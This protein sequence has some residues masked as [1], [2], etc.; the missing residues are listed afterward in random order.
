[1]RCTLGELA[2]RVGGTILGN[3]DVEIH[4]AS[5]LG[6]AAAGEITLIDES[7][8]SQ[9]L[10][11]QTPAVAAVVSAKS[12]ALDAL[13]PHLHRL[14]VD[15]PHAAFAALVALFRPVRP[16]SVEGISPQASIHPTAQLAADV[17]VYP[18]ATI[19]AEATIGAGSVIYPGVYVG[20]CCR[21]GAGVTIFPNAVLYENT[22][23]GD[24][25]VL[26]A[27]VVLGAYG[28]GYRLVDGRHVLSSQL[29]YVEI[30]DD[31]EIGSGS[32]IDR[33]TYGPTVIGAGT[34]LDDQV[35][36][37]HNCRLGRHNLI[38]AQVGLAGS[39]TTGDYVVMAGQVG[40]RDHLHIGDRAV[41]GAKSGIMLDVAPDEQLMGIPAHPL[42]QWKMQQVCL[43]RLPEMRHQLKQLEREIAA[44]REHVDSDKPD[45]QRQAA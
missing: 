28:F 16:R 19:D 5:P 39:T 22:I 42:S 8:K 23:I 27:G 2:A 29:G 7:D 10:A 4:G 17:I 34:K 24:R 20:T 3:P 13:P 6:V 33:G 21:I 35:M 15:E 26:H 31:V 30:G 45:D 38:C 18:G 41:L 9:K 11:T 32:T 43:S 36:I 12:A 1:M 40:V 44:L 25:V 14:V 37:G